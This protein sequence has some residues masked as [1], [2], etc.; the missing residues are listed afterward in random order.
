MI[1]PTAGLDGSLLPSAVVIGPE[2]LVS[3]ALRRTEG[4]RPVPPG[5]SLWTDD[6]AD[7]L[8]AL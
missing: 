8:G 5:P 6:R 3:D 1:H 7:V 4:W 2:G